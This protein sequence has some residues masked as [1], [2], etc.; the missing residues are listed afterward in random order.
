ML[1]LGTICGNRFLKGTPFAKQL[2][3]GLPTS[4]VAL[5]TASSTAPPQQATHAASEKQTCQM[6]PLWAVRNFP[7]TR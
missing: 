1:D 6:S 2:H 4:A 7:G 3:I 5:A